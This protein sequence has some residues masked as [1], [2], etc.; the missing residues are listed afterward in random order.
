MAEK[1][2]RSMVIGIV[3]G[4]VA[5]VAI[6]IGIVIAKGNEGGVEGG[7]EYGEEQVES[8]GMQMDFSNI[9]VTVEYGDYDGMYLLSKDIQNG[10]MLGKVVRI[11]GI[12]SHPMSKYSIVQ[13]DGDGNKIGT[14]FEIEGIDEGE[15]PE[16][17]DRVL[18]TGEIVEK[19]PLYYIIR[20]KPAY[21]ENFGTTDGM[22]ELDELEEYVEVE[23]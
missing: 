13:E 21:V 19:A 1:P 5:I 14:E 12:V 4:V 10:E 9:D 16:D 2:N 23:E 6:I 11:E 22:D 3:V 8:G 20:T 17:A 18:I 7:D 15:Y